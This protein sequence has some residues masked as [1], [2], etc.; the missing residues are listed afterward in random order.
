MSTN[1]RRRGD[2]GRVG[3]VA[4]FIAIA[5]GLYFH[6][7]GGGKID[8]EGIGAGDVVGHSAVDVDII[9]IGRA[10]PSGGGGG[11]GAVGCQRKSSG[12]QAGRSLKHSQSVVLEG[13][14]RA[15]VARV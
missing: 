9:G 7:V 2:A 3:P 6:F 14:P 5:V 15:S 11:G 8:I 10:I 4:G 1:A 13:S 12:R